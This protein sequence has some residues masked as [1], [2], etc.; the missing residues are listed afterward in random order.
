MA[1]GWVRRIVA[2]VLG[3]DAERL[4]PERPLQD[5]GLDS[6]MGL[7][8]RNRL[9][10]ALGLVLPATLVWTFATTAALAGHLLERWQA[11]G[12]VP[13]P[14]APT[15]APATTPRDDLLAAF[16]AALDDIDDLI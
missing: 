1:L 5:L 7:D 9:G 6:V 13:D 12:A 4:D 3:L 8:L 2:G 15:I 14:T 10:A 11:S 16:D